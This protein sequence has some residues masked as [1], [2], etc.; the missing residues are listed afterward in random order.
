MVAWFN[1]EKG[2]G[3][4]Q[5]DDGTAPVFVE[6]SSI[7]ATGYR[8]LSA[9]QPVVFTT[10]AT[11]RGPEARRVRPYTRARSVPLPRRSV[12]ESLRSRK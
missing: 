12:T 7:E 1:S 2:F 4:L 6:F 10:V 5:P 3:F 9:R 11:A 8:T